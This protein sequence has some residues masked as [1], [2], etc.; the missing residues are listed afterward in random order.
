[1]T[2]TSHNFD[3]VTWSAVIACVRISQ[4]L[5]LHYI[6]VFVEL[7]QIRITAPLHYIM[8]SESNT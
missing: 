1:M 5:Q 8:V 6:I 4:E 7:F 2:A 3:G